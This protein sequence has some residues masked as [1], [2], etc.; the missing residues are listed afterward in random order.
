MVRA[1]ESVSHERS[2]GG[3]DRDFRSG[4]PARIWRLVYSVG[5]VAGWQ[6]V[7]IFFAERLRN[8]GRFTVGD[9]HSFR[10]D[11]APVRVLPSCATMSIVLLYLVSQLVGG[12]AV[13]S[14]LLG[15][16]DERA[17]ATEGVLAIL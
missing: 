14:A 8:L 10:L 3:D 16:N 5:S 13:L 7:A 12:G 15:L 4:Q 2:D 9:A 6:L 1:Q 11:Q 17:V